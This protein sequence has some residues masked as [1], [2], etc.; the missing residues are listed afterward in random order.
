[1]LNYH[2][3]ISMTVK[4][5]VK[6]LFQ[7][8]CLAWHIHEMMWSDKLVSASPLLYQWRL[9]SCFSAE[10]ALICGAQNNP[11]GES[12]CALICSIW[13]VS[14]PD[15]ILGEKT[16]LTRAGIQYG[17]RCPGLEKGKKKNKAGHKV[18]ICRAKPSAHKN[19]HG[20]W[21]LPPSGSPD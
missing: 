11:V 5:R 18:K 17:Q 8:G 10:T 2:L 1:M 4:Q 7:R 13:D 19:C 14:V 12:C 21:S 9:S 6:L 20:M 15:I 16:L 3:I